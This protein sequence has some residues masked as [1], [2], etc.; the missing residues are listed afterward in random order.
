MNA[1]SV[2]LEP[3][4]EEAASALADELLAGLE[5]D[6]GT[7]A[8]I[9]ATAEGNPLFLEEMAALAAETDGLIEVPTT[10]RALLQ[11]RLDTL[12]DAERT[13]IDRGAV[14]GKIFHCSAV[15]ALSPAATRDDV[16]AQLLALVRKELVRPDQSQILGD[17]AFRF[18]H[19]LIRDTA[20]ES[21]PKA[22]RAELHERFAEWLDGRGQL[23]EQDEII[24][25]HLENAVQYLREL[26]A[27]DMHAEQLA[28]RAAERLGVAGSTAH[29]RGDIDAA[30]NL[31]GRAIALLPSG[32]ARRRLIPGLVEALLEG[33]T[34]ADVGPLLQELDQGDDVDR[35]S[36]TVLR[37]LNDPAG[38]ASSL[39]VAEADLRIAHNALTVMGDGVSIVRCQRALGLVAWV[40]GQSAE[41]YRAYRRA[42]DHLRILDRPGLLRD[43]VPMLIASAAFSGA[44]SD[45]VLRLLDEIEGSM[46]ADPGPLVKAN[47][48]A[49]RARAEYLSGRIDMEELRSNLE[50]HVDLLGQ[51]GG[52]STSE[53]DFMSV[54]Q[55]IE[56]DFAAQEQTLRD[57]LAEYEQLG[58]AVYVAQVIGQLA[59]TLSR[60]GEVGAALDLVARG[61]RLARAEDVADQIQLDLAEAHA[62]ATR[63]DHAVAREWVESARKRGSAINSVVV[64]DTIDFVDAEVHRAIGDNTRA[65]AIAN[66]AADAARS[67]GQLRYADALRRPSRDPSSSQ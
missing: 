38:S 62:R 64:T 66:R 6:T 5:L 10:I 13:V 17:D 36:A 47:L 51:T 11:A 53:L 54:A 63:G 2:L 41:A 46:G 32:T 34:R 18:R 35:A 24:G 23:L 33:S 1:T 21:L 44:T 67:R 12:N 3:L 56:G 9:L 58:D 4:K 22:V 7:R 65:A 16:P 57:V 15:A 52:R 25:Y 55:W 45:E 8:R 60:R 19:L 39:E 14:E 31:L 28:V 42:Y 37:V 30:R 61:R 26:A 43:V 20:Y 40:A 59:I 50:H 48:A 49:T 29:E 27:E